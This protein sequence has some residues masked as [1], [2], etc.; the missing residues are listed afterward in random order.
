[1]S[2][3]GGFSSLV[4]KAVDQLIKTRHVHVVVSAGGLLHHL[5]GSTDSCALQLAG[6]RQ[7]SPVPCSGI[8]CQ[9]T[10]IPAVTCAG[11]S[12]ND[13]CRASPASTPAAL[14]V[15]AIDQN[16]ARWAYSNWWA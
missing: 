13:A 9:S 12:G 7:Q 5:L 1:M 15:A 10:A 3:E 2:I 16:I 11:N 8:P 14:T 6:V 4:N